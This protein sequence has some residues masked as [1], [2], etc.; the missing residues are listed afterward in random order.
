VL[1]RLRSFLSSLVG[2]IP[3]SG[4]GLLLLVLVGPSLVY[5]ALG[6]QDLVLLALGSGYLVLQALFSLLVLLRGLILAWQL[7]SGRSRV[8]YGAEAERPYWGPPPAPLWRWFPFVQ[9]HWSWLEPGA[10]VRVVRRDGHDLEEVVMHR[11]GVYPS[12][13]REF[14]VTDL[15]GLARIRLRCTQ[16]GEFQVIPGTGQLHQQ[17]LLVRWSNGDEVSDPRGDPTGDRVD[18]RQYTHGDSP[19]TIL[20]KVYARTRRLMVRVPERALAPRPKV[21]AYLVTGPRDEAAAAVCRVLLEGQLLGP[22]WRFG[23]DGAPGQDHQKEAAMDRVCRSAASRQPQP[24]QVLAYLQKAQQDGYSQGIVVLPLDL[25]GHDEAVREALMLSPVP[26]QLCLAIDG[27][28]DSPASGWRRWLVRPRPAQQLTQQLRRAAQ[29][30]NRF[31]G[32]ITLVDRRNGCVLGDLQA[33][34]R[35]TA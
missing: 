26:V 10:D 11:R 33:F 14:T 9:V 17:P 29:L 19:R 2:W 7:R 5:L 32:Q 15:L 23:C 30:W 27:Q 35:R 18:M 28:P 6:S 21:C 8:P 13:T 16:P 3:L 24:D 34:A 12:V 4:L 1:P 31:P 22:D 25:A 20:W